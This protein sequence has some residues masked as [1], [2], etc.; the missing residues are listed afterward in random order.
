MV[1][2]GAHVSISGGISRS[3]ARATDLGL[4]TFQIF[5]KNQRQWEAPPI[6]EDEAGRF[7]SEL[8][9]A[10]LGPV[11][12]HDSYLIN[13]GSPN[14]AVFTR[15]W[16]ALADEISRCSRLGIHLLV[17]H[18]GSHLGGGEKWGL[19]RIAS[20][21]D[22]AFSFVDRRD[23]GNIS[24][25]VLLENT[26]GQGTNLGYDLRQ[27]SQIMDVSSYSERLGICFD[28]CHGFAAGYDIREEEAYHNT[29]EE[30]DASVSLLKLK[31]IH[32]NDASGELGSRRDRHTSI[33]KGMIGAEGFR[34]LMRDERLKSIPA[35]LET[36]GGEDGYRQDLELLRSL[37]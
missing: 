20:G 27:L 5:T 34:H 1:V 32:L 16:E 33:G 14:D 13:L 9:A 15:S 36:P 8:G 21:I 18:P 12:A 4:V 3:V 31:G 7:I 11:M 2:L 25:T 17:A 30:L 6:P 22:E 26:A 35:V 10:D 19:K 23:S 29:L 24:V 28:T 37:V